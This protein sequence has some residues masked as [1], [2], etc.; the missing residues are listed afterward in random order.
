MTATVRAEALDINPAAIDR[1]NTAQVD[2]PR[3]QRIGSRAASRAVGILILG[4]FLTYGIGSTVA[5]ANAGAGG[6]RALLSAGVASMLVNS[7]MVIAIGALVF[8]IVSRYSRPIAGLYLGTRIFEGLGLAVGA[9]ALLTATG[10]DALQVNFVAYNV[11]MAA[12]GIG[13][14]AF[15]ALLFRSGIAPRSLAVLGFVGYA[16]FA[17]GCLLELAGIPG[18]G[19]AS[20]IPGAAFE[21]A[22]GV[23]LIVKGFRTVATRSARA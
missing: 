10:A 9:V 1:S 12:L 17:A 22:F 3:S 23:W 13:S 6:S 2:Q 7:G 4:A 19:L 16:S 18:A 11:A 5:I 15:C 8:P 20:T 21:V 14:L